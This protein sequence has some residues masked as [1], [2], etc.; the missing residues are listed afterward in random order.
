MFS[1]SN[2]S[3]IASVNNL[4]T[5]P[6]DGVSAAAPGFAQVLPVN[7]GSTPV[8]VSGV[9]QWPNVQQQQQQHSLFPATGN[10]STAQQ[11]IQSVSGPSSNQVEL[12]VWTVNFVIVL[13]SNAAFS[14]TF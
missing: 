5:F 7:V 6:L 14:I 13:S 8:N 1:V 11:F 9:T 10:Q 4:S 2:S 3:P 12:L